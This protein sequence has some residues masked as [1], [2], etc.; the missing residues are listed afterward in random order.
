MYFASSNLV[1]YNGAMLWTYGLA[2]SAASIVSAFAG[3]CLLF[4]FLVE[5]SLSM[6]T[7]NFVTGSHILLSLVH[8]RKAQPQFREKNKSI[9]LHFLG[10]KM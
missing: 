4:V 1:L 2:D 9:R 3:V 10:Q 6:C 7:A 8:M 5:A